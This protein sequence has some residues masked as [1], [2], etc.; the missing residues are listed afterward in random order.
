[1][2][3]Q[4]DSEEKNTKITKIM[5]TIELLENTIEK[6]QQKISEINE[7]YMRFEFNKTLSL[8][9]TNSFLKFQVTYIS[10]FSF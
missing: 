1:M 9:K 5:K 4:L 3:K 2:D 8:N 6:I 7:V 10:S